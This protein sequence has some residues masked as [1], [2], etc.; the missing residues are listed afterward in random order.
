MTPPPWHLTRTALVTYAFARRW[1]RSRDEADQREDLLD[2]AEEDLTRLQTGAGFRES[3]RYGRELW[4]SPK[5]TGGGLRWVI[6]PR[7][8]APDLPQV[9]WVGFGAPPNGTWAPR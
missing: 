5:R 9:I 7:M 2:R 8:K 3:D 6:D 1:T 4:R